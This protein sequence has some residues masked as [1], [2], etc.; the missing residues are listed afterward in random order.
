MK[1]SILTTPLFWDLHLHGIAGVDFMAATTDAM[2]F[3]C[4]QLGTNGVGAFAPT[5][6]TSDPKLLTQACQRWGDFLEKAAAKKNFLAPKSAWP[7]GLHL[8]GPF[9]N[10]AMAGAH[11]KE[12]LKK[13]DFSL[14]TDL[15][16]ASQNH[17]AIMTIAPEIPGAETFV[18]KLVRK[19]I[20]IQMGHSTA[21]KEEAL[22]IVRAGATGIT[23]LYNA[24]RT[25]HRDP[26]LLSALSQG[27]VTA[28]MI[29][30]G[31]HVDIDFVHWC[32]KAAPDHI[33]AVSDGCSALGAKS[34]VGLALGSLKIERR[35]DAAY[36]KGTKTLAGG[37]THLCQHPRGLCKAS[38]RD[39]DRKRLLSAFYAIQSRLFPDI[40]RKVRGQNSFNAETLQY[41]GTEF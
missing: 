40:A 18:R 27:L 22:K 7:L 25:H 29:T 34:R 15:L 32:L 11:P 26:G 6:L 17:I 8:E 16:K 24:M 39:S 36:V 35:G 10:P 14:A 41:L 33:Y 9:L 2:V 31:I 30:D 5:L 23:H 1:N 12:W 38:H 21:T 3:A 19:G 28:E 13:S 20:R 37:A 4:E